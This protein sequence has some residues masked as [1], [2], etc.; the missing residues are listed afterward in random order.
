MSFR[1]KKSLPTK[2]EFVYTPKNTD[3]TNIIDTLGT[4][5]LN[6]QSQLTGAQIN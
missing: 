1:V 6:D 4:D 3:E 2:I 5:I